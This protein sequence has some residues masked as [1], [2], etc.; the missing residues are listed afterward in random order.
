MADAQATDGLVP[1]T[2]PS[3]LRPARR[4]PPQ[5]R[6]LGRRVRPRA[7]A[8]LHD[9]RR[10]E[11]MRTY[12]PQ[13]RRSTATF[14]EQKV[15][16]GILDYSHQAPGSPSDR[17][18]RRLRH[19]RLLADRER[20]SVTSR[21]RARRGRRRGHLP[22]QG[23]HQREGAVGH[24]S[25]TPGDG[26]VRRTAGGRRGPSR[27]TWAPTR[28][29]N[30]SGCSLHLVSP[31]EA[32]GHHLL[33][34]EI[35]LPAAFRVPRSEAGRDDVVYKI[36]TQTRRPQLWRPG[37]RGQHRARQRAGT[38]APASRRTLRARRDRRLDQ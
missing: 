8:A 38:A 29:A 20:R 16:G 27:S 3:T 26:H 18:L 32:A 7:L 22:G 36:A 25:T 9:V 28:R 11:T 12:Y 24:V 15:S 23:R 5:R 2:V 21:A 31:V 1:S 17:P 19:V 14:L 13:M 30:E 35:S 33:L 4:H 34:G 37:P 10:Q 6:Q